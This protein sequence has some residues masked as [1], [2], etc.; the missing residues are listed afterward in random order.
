VSFS[1]CVFGKNDTLRFGL[2]ALQIVVIHREV[3]E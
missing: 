1:A 3:G 2:F